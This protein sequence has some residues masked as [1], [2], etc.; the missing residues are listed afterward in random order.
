MREVAPLISESGDLM[1][2]CSEQ[3]A[4]ATPKTEALGQ[5]LAV[6]VR[7][8]M[9]SAALSSRDLEVSSSQ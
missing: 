6:G 7:E 5:L 8:V 9:E 2:I 3:A 4:L 1:G